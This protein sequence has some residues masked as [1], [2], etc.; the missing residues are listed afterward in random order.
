MILI[1]SRILVFI[2][3]TWLICNIT[4]VQIYRGSSII[5]LRVSFFWLTDFLSALV[6]LRFLPSLFRSTDRFSSGV[7]ASAA[8]SVFYSSEFCSMLIIV[9]QSSTREKK[10][11]NTIRAVDLVSE[12]STIVFLESWALELEPEALT[13]KFNIC[14][15]C[16]LSV[17]CLYTVEWRTKVK[18]WAV[19]LFCMLCQCFSVFP[20]TDHDE[21]K[22]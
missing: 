6:L 8:L 16:T 1:L 14:T 18:S 10:S 19:V 4:V 11:C 13:Y 2:L 22:I 3:H 5:L 17:N 12:Y 9:L 21:L 15:V 20:T 7:A